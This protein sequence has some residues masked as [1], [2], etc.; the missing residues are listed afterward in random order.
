VKAGGVASKMT[1]WIEGNS[2]CNLRWENAYNRFETEEE[3]IRKFEKRLVSMG[4]A[5][6]A[7]NVKIVDLFCGSGR[8]L[9][10]LERLGFSDLHGVDLSPRLLSRYSGS[11]QLYV[12]DATELQFPDSW[13]DIVIVQGG[14]HHLPNLEESFGKCLDEI[15]RILK[16]DGLFV[17]VEPWATPFLS[18]AHWSCRRKLIRWI[19]PKVDAL[20]VMIEEERETYYSWLSSA[21]KILDELAARFEKKFLQIKMGKFNFIGSPSRFEG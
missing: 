10:C 1:Y 15:H 12:G 13:A 18:V 8:N 3:E 11:A 14:L 9:I 4:A 20:A 21:N 17:M 5:N 19:S 6:W 7:K 2:C 16:S